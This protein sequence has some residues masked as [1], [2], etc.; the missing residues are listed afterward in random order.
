[1]SR[2]TKPPSFLDEI[3]YPTSA[4]KPVPETDW[5]RD[6]MFA[7][8]Q[9]LT[10]FYAADPRVYVSG[11]LLVFYQ[12]GNRRRHVSP[13][14]FV[15]KGVAKHQRPNYLVWREGRSL[16]L[17]IE[18]T[19]A[20]TRREDCETKFAL[21]RDVLQVK[22]YFQF[23]PFGDFLDPTLQGYRLRGGRYVPIKLVE[24][25]MPSRVL[26]LHLEPDGR[27]LRLWNPVTG[28]R[29]PTVQETI[30]AKDI[31]LQAKDIELQAKDEAL[32]EKDKAL[33]QET[34]NRRLAEAELARLRGE[35]GRVRQ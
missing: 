31:E 35:L 12:P 28:E 11:N 27:D 18:L 2:I 15:V 1:M 5:H 16:D 24:G 10:T 19:S 9:T 20:T 8:I 25:R 21:Y 14:V 29:L 7:L 13:D 17:A 23:D 22:E 6:L 32:R 34:E 33:L 4:R 26:G 30:Q 3:D